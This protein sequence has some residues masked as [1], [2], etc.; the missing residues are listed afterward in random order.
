MFQDRRREF[1]K[2]NY[3]FILRIR[4]NARSIRKTSY[5]EEKKET[6]LNGKRKTFKNVLCDL[7]RN[8]ESSQCAEEKNYKQPRVQDISWTKYLPRNNFF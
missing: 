1:Q 2:K 5:K 6:L 8:T 4:K 7:V 3:L